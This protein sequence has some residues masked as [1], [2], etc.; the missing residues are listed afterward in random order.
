MHWI[1]QENLINPNTRNQVEML[2]RERG[3][4]YTLARLVP[5]ADVLAEDI[6]VPS[7]P[8]FAYGS[9]GIGEVA[10][11][12]G[13]VPGYFDENLDYR[14]MLQNYGQ[15]CLNAGAVV[16][17]LKA[18][19]PVW[20]EFFIRPVFDNKS[21]AGEVMTRAELETFRQGVARV[22]N[23]EFVTLH[24]TDLVLA[25][26]LT[27]IQEEYRFFVIDGVVVTGSRYKVGDR[28]ISSS[29]VPAE[30]LRFAQERAGQWSPNKAYA[31]D[32][33]RTPGGL[34]V[35]ELNSA[36]SAGFYGCDI[37]AIIDAVTA[38]LGYP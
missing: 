6:A 10:K 18:L 19:E 2:L 12:K 15:H 20:A 11:A 23:G 8:L 13:W 27:R 33:A 29:Q 3:I 16:D 25:A 31:L 28:V 38:S 26:P 7:G 36:N 5:I 9:T 21:F 32:I 4:S 22:D 1:L 17:T 14:M 37:G 35:I 30:V 24:M 34:K